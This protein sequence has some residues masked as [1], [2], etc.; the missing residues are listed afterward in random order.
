MRAILVLATGPLLASCAYYV[1]VPASG[2]AAAGQP[3]VA[4]AAP[5]YAYPAPAYYY[6]APYYAYPAYG[7]PAY[8]FFGSVAI[9]G[10]FHIH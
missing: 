9:R 10:R 5:A 4:Q 8:P 3:L 2:S 1:P 7:Y 6:P